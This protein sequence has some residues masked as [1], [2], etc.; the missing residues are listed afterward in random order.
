MRRILVALCS[1]A[2]L[3]K[4]GADRIR[5]ALEGRFPGVVVHPPLPLCQTPSLLAQAIR[6]KGADGVVV[7][8]CAEAEH[9]LAFEREAQRARLAPL[10]LLI[11]DMEGWT[12]PTPKAQVACARAGVILAGAVARLQAGREP[13]PN[14]VRLRLAPLSTPL[15]RRAL[16]RLPPVRL[17]EVAVVESELCAAQRGCRLCVQVCPYQALE[18]ADDTLMV[19]RE[20]C[21]GCG[22]CVPACPTGAIDLSATSLPALRAQVDALLT[23]P[24]AHLPHRAIAFTCP[25][26]PLP[27]GNALPPSVLPVAVPCLG[28]LTLDIP[29]RAVGMG[30]TGIALPEPSSCP[31]QSAQVVR[32]RVQLLGNLLE[33]LG[34]G[35]ERLAVLPADAQAQKDAL[36]RLANL[37]PSA[38][39]DA[40]PAGDLP[41]LLLALSR[42]AGVSVRMGHPAS[43]LGIVEVSGAC[44]LCGSCATV[45]PPSALLLHQGDREAT[46]SFHSHRCTACGM[47]APACPEG[48]I[49]LW[50][51]V[52]TACLAQGMRVVARTPQ[53]LC[54]SCG[55]PFMPLALVK[56]VQTVLAQQGIPNLEAFTTLCPDCRGFP[57]AR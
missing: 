26:R 38:P 34:I 5:Q 12:M 50:R 28:L 48:A 36:R 24:E 1:C 3:N 2:G 45:C 16:F 20:R 32:E 15:T 8:A 53:A 47:C 40:V 41:T 7:G 54:R 44:T 27:P 51:G 55:R 33:A 56:K 23:F 9:H 6:E 11:V 25:C 19:L 10:A 42:R 18:T 49:A 39:L 46:L 13:T 29:L 22:L 31:H 52:D 17:Q 35:R 14:A 30:A 21:E 43:P 37:P 57:T 4:E